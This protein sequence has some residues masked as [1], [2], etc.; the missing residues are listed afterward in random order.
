MGGVGM[1]LTEKWIK[2]TKVVSVCDRDR[3][4]NFRLVLENMMVTFISACATEVGLADEPKTRFYK[5]CLEI[6]LMVNDGALIIVA[7]DF[8]KQVQQQPNECCGVHGGYV[9]GSKN[10]EETRLLQF[11][12]LQH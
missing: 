12:D 6:T 2:V 9:F 10:K 11:C 7:G 4:I 8:N 3:I 5:A 1:L